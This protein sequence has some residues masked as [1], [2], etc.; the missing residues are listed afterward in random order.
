MAKR[1]LFATPVGAIKA[2]QAFQRLGWTQ[3]Y[4]AAQV[5][6]QTR[7]PI[8]KFF[9]GK[10]IERHIFID[11][12]FQLDLEWQEIAG[13]PSPDDLRATSTAQELDEWVQ[14]LR[15]YQQGQL[16]AQCGILQSSLDV[17][18]TLQLS[19]IYTGIQTLPQ[20][21]HQ[22]W[23]EISELQTATESTRFMPVHDDLTQGAETI[24]AHS[25]L[26]IVGKPGAG[27]TT[28]LQHIAL[29]CQGNRLRPECI[30]IF[31]PLRML[32]RT[33]QDDFSIVDYISRVWNG[34]G[35]ADEQLER[36]LQQGRVLILLDG[37]DEV[38]Q[39]NSQSLIHQIQDFADQYYQCQIIVT[40]RIAAQSYYF[41]GFT[42][43]EL[44]DFN[45]AQIEAFARRYFV[46]TAQNSKTAGLSKA[47][48]FFE[49]LQQH[50]NQPI[51]ELV[52]SPL[53]LSLVCS[54]FQERSSFPSN[55]AK[56]YKAALDIL[57]GRWDQARGIHRD[58]TYQQLSRAQK[59]TL[60]GQIAATTFEQGHF[61]FEKQDVLRIIAGYLSSFADV[62]SDPEVLWQAS[63]AVLGSIVLQHG[64]LVERAR[65]VYSFSHLTFQEYLA[66]RKIVATPPASRQ[67]ALAHLA[68]HVCDAQW[69]EVL[70]LTSS[71]L[72]D[73]TDLVQQIQAQIQGLAHTESLQK[74]LAGLD[75]KVSGLELDCKPA[76]VRAFYFSLLFDRD[77]NLAIAL[78][79][80]LANDLPDALA[81]DLA[82]VRA[83]NLSL[84]LVKGSSLKEILNFSFALD[85]E[86]RFTFETPLRQ[87]WQALKEKL[88]DPAMGEINLQ[89]WWQT[90]GLQWVESFQAWLTE[91]R[92]LNWP[93]K[94][95]GQLQQY[96][97]ANQRLVDCLSGECRL[98]SELKSQLQSTV[99][100]P[101]STL[102]PASPCS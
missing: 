28:F 54:V 15:T 61:Y 76:A 2:K 11:L 89:N 101:V 42:Y 36:L 45:Q 38:A 7:Q 43:V 88:P 16:Q 12:C 39:E 29:E 92:H 23:L 102:R 48:Q 34:S 9:T 66:A 47:T 51:R 19:E 72:P 21:T 81:L 69:R 26:V 57:L 99:L 64:L 67:Q 84:P 97:Q 53:L 86:Q 20:L 49:Q 94:G 56:L 70:L 22:R 55:R 83:F 1:S 6:V 33:A 80:T 25:K 41:R 65:D 77:L 37:L 46:A 30:P 40:C 3:E 24:K 85:L 74:F 32:T 58:T 59:I 68:T 17:T 95:Q 93:P 4:L 14:R 82:F 62:S 8:W 87:S 63:E 91:H 50:E 78:D 75:R 13:L 98:P 60:M 44:A 79:P 52:V 10:P 27:K 90:D 18:H 35:L 5:S 71:M 73:A 100:Q 96:Y 31:I